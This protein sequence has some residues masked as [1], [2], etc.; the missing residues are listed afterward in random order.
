MTFGQRKVN[1]ISIFISDAICGAN[2]FEEI[3]K[4]FYDK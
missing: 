3:S 2:G 1:P 4:L